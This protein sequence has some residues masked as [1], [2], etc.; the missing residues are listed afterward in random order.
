MVSA[1]ALSTPAALAHPNVPRRATVHAPSPST[2]PYLAMLVPT[3]L[4]FAAP[5]RPPVVLKIDPLTPEGEDPEAGSANSADPA[6]SAAGLPGSPFGEFGDF[7]FALPNTSDLDAAIAGEPTNPD[8]QTAN[9]ATAEADKPKGPPPI[10]LNE[11]NLSG[12]RPEDIMPFF[13]LPSVPSKATYRK[14]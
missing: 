6:A 1:C 12:A 3:P 4:R 7:N 5:E 11:D 14:Q 9:D 8:A 13:R 10:I 2:H